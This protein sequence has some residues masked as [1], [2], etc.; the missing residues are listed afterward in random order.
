MKGSLIFGAVLWKALKELAINAN[1]SSA[2]SK[3]AR[4][5]IFYN[6]TVI[7]GFFFLMESTLTSQV[8]WLIHSLQCIWFHWNGLTT[9]LDCNGNL[10]TSY[11]TLNEAYY[12]K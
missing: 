8:S 6:G 10:H 2:I 1:E 3:A 11:N 12:I 4:V 9:V 5:N 7:P